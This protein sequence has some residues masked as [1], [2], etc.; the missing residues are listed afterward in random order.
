MRRAP[1][2]VLCLAGLLCAGMGAAQA[3]SSLALGA[4]RP[5]PAANVRQTPPELA[6]AL[7]QAR[8]LGSA[9]LKVWGFEVYDSR[10]W[11]TPAFS[12]ASPA[13]SPLALELT[14]LRDFK[15]QDIAERSL[16]EMR[17]S[18][19]LSDAQA[20]RWKADLLR[21]IPD[22]RAGDRILGVHRPGQG[23]AFWVNDKPAGEVR[24]E[25]FSARFFGIWLSPATSE[26]QM[27]AALL[28]GAAP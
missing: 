3:E 15:A 14:Y 6:Q 25:D 22:V 16:K 10:L 28:A 12:A 20:A 9:R 11:A 19:P 21:V 24:D 8:L 13:A 2:L 1:A 7:P 27:R 23:A 18:Q 17:R 4:S 5:A 26:P